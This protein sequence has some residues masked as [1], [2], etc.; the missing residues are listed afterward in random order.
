[1]TPNQPQTRYQSRKSRAQPG[2]RHRVVGL[3]LAVL[4]GACQGDPARLLVQVP[5]PAPSPVSGETTEA[6]TPA[7]L[8]TQ[9]VVSPAQARYLIEQGALVLDGRDRPLRQ[10]EPI[11]GAIAIRW[12]DFSPSTDPHQGQL[13]ADD[14]ALTQ[15]LQAIGVSGSQPAVV[16]GDPVNGWGQDGR[17]VWMLRSLG[18]RQAVL[19]DGGAAALRQTG[20]SLA[21]TGPARLGAGPPPGGFVV[22]RTSQWEISQ[23]DLR[24]ALD[25]HTLV[26]VDARERREFEGAVPYGERRGGHIPGAIQLYYKELMDSEGRLLPRPAIAALLQARGIATDAVVVSY[27]TGGVRSGWLTTVLVDLGFEAKNYAGSMWEWSAGDPEDYPLVL[28][29]EPNPG[30]TP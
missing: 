24:R 3:G 7:Q 30:R 29:A 26:I 14:A 15:R 20:L 12:Q 16:V 9:W 17:V 4:L 6:V 22:H 10:R 25:T 1:M 28:P 19:V 5:Q 11:P 27:C 2:S 21:P 13:L 18:H 8:T 23:A